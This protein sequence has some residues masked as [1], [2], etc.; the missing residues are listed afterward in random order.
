M[1]TRKTKAS[2]NVVAARSRHARVV[3]DFLLPLEDD[4][5]A[6]IKTVGN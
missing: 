1:P 3:Q 2:A 5:D 6:D 4:A